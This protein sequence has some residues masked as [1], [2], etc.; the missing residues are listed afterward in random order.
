MNRI[1][2]HDFPLAIRTDFSDDEAWDAF[3]AAMDE[4]DGGDDSVADV[5]LFDDPAYRDLTSDEL[6]QLLPEDYED[7]F[8]VVVDGPAL[9]SPELP[10]LIVDLLHEPGRSFRVTA[11][12]LPE[13]EANLSI[14]NMD[15]FDYA[16]SVEED[17]VFR[18]FPERGDASRAL[19]GAGD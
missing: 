1:P 8:F 13:I 4:P 6:M 10:V 3:V 2:S 9:A 18:G 16:D 15:F 11:A 7:S 19:R 12:E 5:E 14:S 17:G